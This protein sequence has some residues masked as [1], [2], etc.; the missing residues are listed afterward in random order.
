MFMTV[1]AFTSPNE[2]I[3]ENFCPLRRLDVGEH[4]VKFLHSTDDNQVICDEYDTPLTQPTL[5]VITFGFAPRSCP[6]RHNLNGI[7]FDRS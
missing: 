3:S 6:L 7:N 4:N 1:M 2:L 5:R